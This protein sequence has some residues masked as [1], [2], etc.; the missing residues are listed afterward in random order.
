MNA[1][2]KL[3]VALTLLSTSAIANADS[4]TYD[5]TGTVE[6]NNYVSNIAGPGIWSTIAVGTPVSGSFT[7]DLGAGNPAQSSGAA[8]SYASAGW[9]VQN[10]GGYQ[11][12]SV[13]SMTI[14]FGHFSYGWPAPSDS[15]GSVVVAPSTTPS[16]SQWQGGALYQPDSTTYFQS[17][18]NLA[19]LNGSVAY[20][21]DGLPLIPNLVLSNA[22][23]SA[24]RPLSWIETYSPPNCCT[25]S[26]LVYEIDALALAPVPLPAAAWLL[27]SG[28]GGLGVLGRKR[29]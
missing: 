1:L 11:T 24:G 2:S 10:D 18:V 3:S 15:L 22:P 26:A 8:G 13:F 9:Y 17:I 23:P 20:G 6:P 27:L 12:P 4:V 28:L 25:G 7:V 29:K 14:Q 16:G 21:P 5:F 19:G